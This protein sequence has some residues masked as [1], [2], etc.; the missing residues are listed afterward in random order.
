V[1]VKTPTGK[2]VALDVSVRDSI[3]SVKKMMERKEG[4][5][6]GEGR[7]GGRGDVSM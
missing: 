2:Q 1:Y 7:G 5:G 6:R 4:V 3:P